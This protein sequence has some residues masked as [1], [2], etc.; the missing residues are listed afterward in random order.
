[1]SFAYRFFCV[2][3]NVFVKT[4]RGFYV[5][6]GLWKIVKYLVDVEYASEAPK[7]RSPNIG[8]RSAKWAKLLMQFLPWQNAA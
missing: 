4:A 5:K 2:N 1:M 7:R 6:S 3:F 8:E